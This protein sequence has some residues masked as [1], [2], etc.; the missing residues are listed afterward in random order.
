MNC[1]IRSSRKEMAAVI[2]ACPGDGVS[3]TGFS[4]L[5]HDTVIDDERQV[6]LRFKRGYSLRLDV[7]ILI[8]VFIRSCSCLTIFIGGR[9]LTF[10]SVNTPT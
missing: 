6:L 2:L 4:G 10:G 5:S 7:T 3:P 8:R 9:F 1:S